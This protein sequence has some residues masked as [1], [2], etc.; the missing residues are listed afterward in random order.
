LILRRSCHLVSGSIIPISLRGCYPRP[1]LKPSLNSWPFHSLFPSYHGFRVHCSAWFLVQSFL[2]KFPLHH[3]TLARRVILIPAM[4][5][6]LRGPKFFS[7]RIFLKMFLL[8]HA[9]AAQWDAFLKEAA[10]FLRDPRSPQ[11]S[12][13]GSPHHPAVSFW[14][15]C[16][17]FR[18]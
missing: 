13:F 15:L 18:P 6:S 7:V 2:T 3:A 9:T 11:V 10:N 14:P 5:N 1:S 8:H 16:R 17:F 12:F 4:A